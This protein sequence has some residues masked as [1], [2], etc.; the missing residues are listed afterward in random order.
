MSF[1]GVAHTRG[2]YGS[3]MILLFRFLFRDIPVG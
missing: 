3:V 1:E 2:R